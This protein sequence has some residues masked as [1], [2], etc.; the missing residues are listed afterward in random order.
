MVIWSSLVLGVMAFPDLID[1]L[2]KARKDHLLAFPEKREVF[3]D[4]TSFKRYLYENFRSVQYPSILDG[5]NV[6]KRDKTNMTIN[7]LTH[8]LQRLKPVTEV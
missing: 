1:R 5:I 3:S 6:L 4:I 8:N 7:Q 2:N